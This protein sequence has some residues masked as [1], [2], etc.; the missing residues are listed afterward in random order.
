M[1][2]MRV[3]FINNL[4]K[5]ITISILWEKYVGDAPYLIEAEAVRY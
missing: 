5:A 1:R 3:C 4:G 2:G